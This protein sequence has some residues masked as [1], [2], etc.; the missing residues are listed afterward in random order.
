[1]FSRSINVSFQFTGWDGQVYDVEAECCVR[2]DE[3]WDE[4]GFSPISAQI[5]S[6][7][8]INPF[9]NGEQLTWHDAKL[10]VNK[11]YEDYKEALE[12]IVVNSVASETS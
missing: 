8:L 10:F 6:M 11:Y 12:W 9:V 2:W 1:M 7:E 4:S 5:Y 3:A